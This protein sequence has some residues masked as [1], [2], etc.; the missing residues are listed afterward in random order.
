VNITGFSFNALEEPKIP[1]TT[2]I[3]PQ[4]P[5][6]VSS[7]D[8]EHGEIEEVLPQNSELDFNL[9]TGPMLLPNLP[10]VGSPPKSHTAFQDVE[11]GG[12][13]SSANFEDSVSKLDF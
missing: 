5:A 12:W 1:E 3:T 7:E 9:S 8:Q 10:R 4:S 2:E 6:S 11:F 13:D